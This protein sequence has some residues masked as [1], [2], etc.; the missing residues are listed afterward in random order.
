MLSSNH[1]G[2]RDM[3]KAVCHVMVPHAA[4][5]RCGGEVLYPKFKI[6]GCN[7][8]IPLKYHCKLVASNLSACWHQQAVANND[9]S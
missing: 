9:E 2:K 3:R 7:L 1:Q 5:I 6:R 4:S 8:K